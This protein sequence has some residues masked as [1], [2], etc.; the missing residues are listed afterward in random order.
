MKINLTM[1]IALSA[2]KKASFIAAIDVFELFTK[3]ASL[4]N[5]F[6]RSGLANT[7]IHQN[8]V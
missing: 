7:V 8:N 3:I 4:Q 5:D 6:Q 2:A 1:I